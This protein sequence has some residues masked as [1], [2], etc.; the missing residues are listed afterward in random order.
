M[1][2]GRV[3]MRAAT[4]VCFMFSAVPMAQ[5]MNE[6]RNEVLHLADVKPFLIC[7]ASEFLANISIVSPGI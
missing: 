7:I 6:I 3:Q 5:C 1:S 2:L 4:P